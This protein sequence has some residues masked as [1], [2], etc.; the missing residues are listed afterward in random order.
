[1]KLWVTGSFPRIKSKNFFVLT[2]ERLCE[3]HMKEYK[4]G[5]SISGIF[6]FSS[7]AVSSS[8]A[9]SSSGAVSSS[10]AVSSSGA[11]SSSRAVSSPGPVSSSGAIYSPGADALFIGGVNNS[12]GNTSPG[13]ITSS[14]VTGSPKSSPR[15]AIDCCPSGLTPGVLLRE[16]VAASDSGE[17]HLWLHQQEH[18]LEL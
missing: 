6:C 3:P 8:R 7:G 13:A 4:Y 11:V 9:I 5:S 12:G 16:V 10:R 2:L 14:K 15:G 18:L 17:H 1:M